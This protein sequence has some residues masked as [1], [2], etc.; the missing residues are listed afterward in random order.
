[1]SIL[2]KM[3]ACKK[4]VLDIISQAPYNIIIRG[5]SIFKVVTGLIPL[6]FVLFFAKKAS[7]PS[8]TLYFDN[9]YYL[10]D[11]KGGAL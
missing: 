11:K 2:T 3:D 7:L 9:L 10:L 1:M 8:R 4:L 5:F 6:F